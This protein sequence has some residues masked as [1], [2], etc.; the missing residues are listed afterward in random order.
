MEVV[1]EASDWF[2]TVVEVPV[3]HVDMLLLDWDLLPIN[4]PAAALSGLRKTC[5]SALVV[6]FI[7]QEDVQK[8]AALSV[9]ADMFITKGETTKRM[10]ERL[11]AVA[12]N[13]PA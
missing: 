10:A 12:S 1:G 3:S 4:S 6:I 7:S 8:Q 13:I 5:P 9:M 2:T 11:E